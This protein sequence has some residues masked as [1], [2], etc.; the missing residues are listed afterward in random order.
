MGPRAKALVD[1]NNHNLKLSLN[2]TFLKYCYMFLNTKLH[3]ILRN[4]KH[5][6]PAIVKLLF[7]KNRNEMSLKTVSIFLGVTVILVT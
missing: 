3:K 4:L 2:G 5:K 1:I 6:I 7:K